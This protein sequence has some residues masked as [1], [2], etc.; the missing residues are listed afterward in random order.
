MLR[1]ISSCVGRRCMNVR[2]EFNEG[3]PTLIPPPMG[4]GLNRKYHQTSS[5]MELLAIR[6]ST[7]KP[8]KS[9]VISLR[10]R[11]G[12]VEYSSNTAKKVGFFPC[13]QN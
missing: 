1:R 10:G 5:L 4:E 8:C 12:V 6:L 7:I 9:L 2:L 3:S 13:Q 11:A